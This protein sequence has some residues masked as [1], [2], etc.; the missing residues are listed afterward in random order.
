MPKKKY[1]IIE[2]KKEIIEVDTQ[3][4]AIQ[5]AKQR[6]Q[7]RDVEV[8]EDNTVEIDD[9][10]LLKEIEEDEKRDEEEE[11]KLPLIQKNSFAL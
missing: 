7:D 5:I 10:D 1:F 4:E 6:I 11:A 3:Q 8:D 2:F 9:E